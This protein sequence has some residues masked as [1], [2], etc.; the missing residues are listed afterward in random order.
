M[1]S[2]DVLPF[3]Q[4][5]EISRTE[6]FISIET[7]SGYSMVQREDDGYV[8]NL[9]PGAADEE[10]GRALLEALKWSRFIWPPDEWGFFEAERYEQCYQNWE[11]DIMQRYGYKSTRDLH[12]NM[13]WC[14]AK[15]SEGKILIRP[16]KRDKPG[17]WSDLPRERDVVIAETNNAAAVG[18]ALRLAL[19]RC[20]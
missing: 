14:R 18:A 19:D 4:W 11:K 17:Y 16:H 6:R 15:R 2:T 13:D 20:E 10:L 3:A 8:V 12:K 1:K 5:A 7:L 9:A